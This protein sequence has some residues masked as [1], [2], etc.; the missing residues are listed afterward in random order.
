MRLGLGLGLGLRLG[1]GYR[2]PAEEVAQGVLRQEA[3]RVLRAVGQPHAQCHD[4][5]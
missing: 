5:R 1:L 3:L 2:Q 4:V